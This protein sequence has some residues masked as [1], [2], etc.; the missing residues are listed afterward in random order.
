EG[1]VYELPFV[2]GSFDVAYAHQVLQHLRERGLALREM[3]RVVKPGGI[4][5]VRE[6]DWSTVAYFPRDPWIDR[7][8]DVHLRTWYRNGVEPQAGRQLRA[9]FQPAGGASLAIPARAWGYAPREGT[10]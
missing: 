7:F 1:S 2:D 9:L 4:V 10:P 5:A 8:I 3:L 6:V